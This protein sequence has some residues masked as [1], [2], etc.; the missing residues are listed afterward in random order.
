[1][2]SPSRLD[3]RTIH[4]QYAY[5][6]FLGL[7]LSLTVV[8]IGLRFVIPVAGQAFSVRSSSISPCRQVNAPPHTPGTRVYLS[9]A[10][11]AC[12]CRGV[13]A[14]L[15]CT[16]SVARFSVVCRG[17][18]GLNMHTACFTC[19]QAQPP[20]VRRCP[21]PPCTAWVLYPV[22]SFAPSVHWRISTQA[23]TDLRGSH[24]QREPPLRV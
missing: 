23:G 10:A 2:V 7:S 4:G 3:C 1:M 5:Q 13:S 19:C 21:A 8:L 17:I 24:Y 9:L 18:G 20:A 6:T 15:P 14:V 16:A 22:S 12:R 11:R